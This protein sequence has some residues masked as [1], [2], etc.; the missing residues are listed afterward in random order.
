MPDRVPDINL[1]PKY[2]R[3]SSLPYILFI[4]LIVITVFAY[5]LITYYFFSTKS[6]LN[7]ADDRYAELDK[8]VLSLQTEIDGLESAEAS[9]KDAVTFVEQYDMPTSYVIKEVNDTLPDHSYLSFYSY[10]NQKVKVRS[11]FES[12]D[13]MSLYTTRLNESDT[14]NDTKIDVITSFELGEVN[15]D[16]E[17]FHEQ[18]RYEADFDLIVN[19]YYL[20]GDLSEYE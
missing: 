20:K 10:R 15:E 1:L 2:E 13:D 7:K 5:G 4:I 8:E 14:F 9:L 6:K 3:E 11:Q 18:L 16:P 12:L 19:R 17:D